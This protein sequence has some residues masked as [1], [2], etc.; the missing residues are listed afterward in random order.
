MRSRIN[1]DRFPRLIYRTLLPL[2]AA[3]F[4]ASLQAAAPLEAW[5]TQFPSKEKSP[6]L[7]QQLDALGKASQGMPVALQPA[8]RF[9]NVFLKILA[10]WKSA[11]WHG[12][13]EALAGLPDNS[14]VVAGV[15]EVS[16]AWL[17]RLQMA[18]IDLILRTY[19][20]NHV[21]FP[22]TLAEIENDLPQ[23]V[24][25]DP[26]GEPWIY[27]PR[28]PQGFERLVTQRYQLGPTRFPNLAPLPEAM[29]R[30]SPETHPWTISLRDAAGKKAIEVRSPGKNAAVSIIEPGGKI[31]G[32]TLLFI[33]DDWA[34]MAGSDQ[35]F[36]V[37]VRKND[38]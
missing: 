15:R 26:W 34:L 35:L 23:N 22:A 3:G 5:P 19:Y 20:R 4:A 32:C 30:R 17:A 21:R 33:G 37:G 28:A 10:G 25:K 27:K 1:A 36:T 9:Q 8:V 11:E 29:T 12:E 14:P 24:R 38:E 13:I 7:K 2:C 18:E 6:P 16:R 31:D